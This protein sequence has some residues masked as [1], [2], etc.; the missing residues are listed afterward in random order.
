[1]AD[2]D[3]ILVTLS[4]L[5]A[6]D[7]SEAA[8]QLQTDDTFAED[9]LIMAQGMFA[10]WAGYDPFVHAEAQDYHADAGP[11]MLGGVR[12]AYVYA[13]ARPVVA[14]TTDAVY[15]TTDGGRLY[16]GTAPTSGLSYFAGWRRNDQNLGALQALPGLSTL[17][18]APSVVPLE[19]R[20]AICRAAVYA[21]LHSLTGWENSV[22]ID[23][24]TATKTVT[25]PKPM[26]AGLPEVEALF[27]LTCG[28][29]R[30]PRL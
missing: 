9:A 24:G 28:R 8:A 6:R 15:A 11:Y 7:F 3:R 2:L 1:M 19:V 17:T 16:Y 30:I 10:T 26:N 25:G 20:S 23:M 18:V 5:R 29:Y 14:V 4:E 27:D 13:A 21:A 12:Y 22:E